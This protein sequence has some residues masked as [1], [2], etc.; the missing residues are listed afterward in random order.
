MAASAADKKALIVYGGFTGHEPEA[1]TERVAAELRSHGMEVT[2]RDSLEAFADED[3]MRA[4]D[5]II[6]NWTMGEL[7][8]EQQQGITG[9]AGAGI[10]VGGWHGGMCDAFRA[11]IGYHY[12]TGG[13]FVAHP[14]GQVDYTV[15]ITGVQHPITAGLR[16]FPV[17]S[18]QYYMLT[19][20]GNQI[21]ATTTFSG[22]ADPAIA[23]TV[24]P[25][26]WTRQYGPQKSRVFYSALGHQAHEFDQEEVRTICIRGLLW[27]AGAL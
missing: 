18:E 8:T 2:L 21:L 7:S 13:Q 16:S 26:V 10:G 25:V 24:M 20:P 9:A 19:D 4:Q 27:A 1:C 6:P 3:L 22:E 17:H 14:G 5:L 23:G 12:L 11:S 15:D